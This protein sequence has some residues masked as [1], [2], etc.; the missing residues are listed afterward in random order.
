MIIRGTT[1]EMSIDSDVEDQDLCPVL[2]YLPQGH[3]HLLVQQRSWLQMHRRRKQQQRIPCFRQCRPKDRAILLLGHA[4]LS[5]ST[6]ISVAVSTRV[7]FQRRW[8]A[9]C[10]G[11]APDMASSDNGLAA[12]ADMPYE[13][14]KGT[15]PAVAVAESRLASSSAWADSSTT[16]HADANP[17][18]NV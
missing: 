16:P 15:E 17:F 1:N 6:L 2:H 3:F 4:K 14:T 7:V 9:L 13:P 10:G 8:N 5:R 11:S 18:A 12:L